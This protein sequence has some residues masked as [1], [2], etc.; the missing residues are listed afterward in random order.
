MFCQNILGPVMLE[1]RMCV[2]YQ[3]ILG[4]FSSPKE[5]GNHEGGSTGPVSRGRGSRVDRAQ[6]VAM[7]VGAAQPGGGRAAPVP[8]SVPACE[9]G[10]GRG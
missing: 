8:W 3:N 2:F 7:S 6:C 10:G 4:P 1:V 9:E 5:G